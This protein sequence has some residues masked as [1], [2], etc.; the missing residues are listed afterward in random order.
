[1]RHLIVCHTTKMKL[2]RGRT[3]PYWRRQGICCCIL[4]WTNIIRWA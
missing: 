4:V 2:L 3:K 1:V